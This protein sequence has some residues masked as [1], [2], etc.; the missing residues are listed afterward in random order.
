MQVYLPNGKVAGEIREGTFY[1]TFHASRHLLRK[2]CP[3]L[4]I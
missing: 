1:R 3:A 2:P 4:A